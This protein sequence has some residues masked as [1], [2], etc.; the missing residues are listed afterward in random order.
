MI[1]TIYKNEIKKDIVKVII[2]PDIEGVAVGRG[3]G[4][5]IVDVPQNIKKIS[6]T[7]I[8]KGTNNEIPEEIKKIIEI[9]ENNK[10]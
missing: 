2:I 4:Y 7:N 10:K 5:Y 9:F 3:V 8:R 1:E 6:G